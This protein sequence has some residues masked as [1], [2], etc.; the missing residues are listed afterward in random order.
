[1]KYLFALSLLVCA[2]PRASAIEIG[3]LPTDW[4]WPPIPTETFPP[5]SSTGIEKLDN[6]HTELNG[7][8]DLLDY[9]DDYEDDGQY[10]TVPAVKPVGMTGPAGDK[11][12][13][14]NKFKETETAKPGSASDAVRSSLLLIGAL[15]L[16]TL[17]SLVYLRL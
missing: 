17:V 13:Q 2:F 15:S 1:M 9:E 8:K 16:N 14:K 3:P 6:V 11:P 7:L 10:D 5:P 4:V 12:D